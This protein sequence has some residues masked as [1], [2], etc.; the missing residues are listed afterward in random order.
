MHTDAHDRSPSGY[1][2]RTTYSTISAISGVISVG[3]LIVR[4]DVRHHI[5][6]G[7]KVGR[8]SGP[9]DPLVRFL[10]RPHLPSGPKD[11]GGAPNALPAPWGTESTPVW[12]GPGDAHLPIR[13]GDRSSPFV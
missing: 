12:F 13:G 4:V 2:S 6:D 1:R 9:D 11:L 10:G 3:R 7:G 5:I 8:L